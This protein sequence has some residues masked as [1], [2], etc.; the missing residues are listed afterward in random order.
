MSTEK[1]SPSSASKPPIPLKTKLLKP[2]GTN[3]PSTGVESEVNET[4]IIP[5]TLDKLTS[6]QRH[7][8]EQMMSSVKDKFMNS[9]KE[10]RQGTIVQKYKLK[11]VAADEVGSSSSQGGKCVVDALG[12]KGDGL[13]D[14][15]VE[16]LGE[17]GAEVQEEPPRCT[18]FH[19]QVDYAVQHALINQSG[20]I[21]NTLTNMFKSVM[22]GTI[23]EHQNT[24]PVYL[25][26]GVFPNYRNLVIGNQQS[27]SNA[28]P[29]QLTVAASTPAPAAPSSVQRQTINPRLFSREQPQH[30][31]QNISR[32][33]Q[34]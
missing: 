18:N 15:V 33:S 28:P 32:L 8:L 29:V 10:T 12:D 13:Q 2:P 21:V 3:L 7:E 14:G 25:P 23:A 26:G 9:F 22:V 11:V 1:Q 6:E 27:T 5:I 24:G 19:D 31:G 16:D 34:D 20:E 30:A 4:N 17:D